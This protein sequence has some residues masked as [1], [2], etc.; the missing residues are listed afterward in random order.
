MAYGVLVSGANSNHHHYIHMLHDL[1]HVEVEILVNCLQHESSS[2][3][4]KAVK[5]VQDNQYGQSQKD[6]TIPQKLR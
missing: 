6:T 1:P 2:G 3:I 5:L 4:S